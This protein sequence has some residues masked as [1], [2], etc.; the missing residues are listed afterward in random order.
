MVLKNDAIEAGLTEQI[1]DLLTV[2]H[3]L[4]IIGSK[5]VE[6]SLPEIFSIYRHDLPE[7]KTDDAADVKRMLMTVGAVSMQ[8]INKVL[9]V[10]VPQARSID[11]TV[12]ALRAARGGT[13]DKPEDRTIRGVFPFPRCP[14]YDTFTF[15][16][17][18]A[19]FTRN[20]AHVPDTTASIGVL[21]SILEIK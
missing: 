6:L 2:E 17:R 3:K 14:E 12:T 7:Q 15:W 1:E 8:G 20:R 5:I 9:A 19:Y 18:A 13:N 11:E 16:E 4:E 10:E 21:R